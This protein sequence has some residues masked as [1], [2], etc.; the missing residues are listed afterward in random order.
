[1]TAPAP[2][3]AT[4][5]DGTPV[6]LRPLGPDDR[7]LLEEGF[8]RLSPASRY[9]RFHSTV[10]RLSA[11]R[12]DYLLDVDQRDHLAWVAV[13]RAGRREVGVGVAR[14]VRLMDEPAVA[15][16]ALTVTDD[17]HGRG[18]G[19]LLLGALARA[20]R[21]AGIATFRNYVLAGNDRMLEVLAELGATRELE[22]PGVW[23]VDLPV[24]APGDALPDTPAGRAFRAAAEGR[25]SMEGAPPVWGRADGGALRVAWDRLRGRRPR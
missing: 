15:E 14:A 20:A 19:T 9:H 22:S 12:L 3:T 8:A 18:A 1:M 21:A 2:L 23:R 25:L 11:R 5:R 13:A 4:L 24:P 17:Y 16:A 6:L 7:D 10:E